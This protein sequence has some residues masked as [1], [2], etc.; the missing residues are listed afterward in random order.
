MNNSKAFYEYEFKRKFSCCLYKN[1]RLPLGE[2]EFSQNIERTERGD[3]YPLIYSQGEYT[4]E[5]GNGK[6]KLESENGE[7]CRLMGEFVPMAAYEII[8]GSLWGK[9]GFAFINDK[10]H[11]KIT[12]EKE[13]NGYY[14]CFTEN[15]CEERFELNDFNESEIV[16]SVQNR[17]EFF[18][19]YLKVNGFVKFITTFTASSFSDCL[20]ESVFSNTKACF[21]AKGN[22]IIKKASFFM[23]SGVS[24]ADIRAVKY[25]NGEVLNE[26]GKMYFT[27]SVRLESGGY[28]AVVSWVP[29]TEK[30][31]IV[32][33]LFFDV[34]DGQW[35]GDV[36]TSL[37]YDRK[38]SEWLLWVCSFSHGHI[39]GRAIMDSDPR[40]GRNVID[41]RL[42]D[43]QTENNDD[44][45]FLGKTGDED[46]DL[47]YDE[48]NGLWY[49]AIC[50]VSDI[51][52]KY[53]YHFFESV[54]P[55]DGFR[56]IGKGVCGS[57]TG[58]SFVRLNGEI[59]FVCGNGFEIT[60]EYRVYKFGEFDKFNLIKCDY[61]D[62]G[63]RGWGTV[64]GFNAATRQ[65][66]Y[67]MTFDRHLGSDFNWS[68]GN[69]YCFEAHI[70]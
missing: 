40:F 2:A 36:A 12:V 25:E 21:Y 15:G 5:S 26:N 57:E 13:N 1:L 52:G 68:Y 41:I 56:F 38:S 51:N 61:P 27:L 64:F 69:L 37:V 39:L 14:L 53:C 17:R 49:L 63:F 6:Y 65:R 11:I 3:K 54:N 67:F 44:A 58:G 18:D 29:G 28:Q 24:Q 50:R 20:Y 48:K 7:I 19:V 16:F 42:M 8:I 35:C 9:C 33:A 55:L 31:E 23:D 22:V 59:Y 70:S 10:T 4:E 60:S 30:F 32:G 34:G 43:K 62:G 45:A 46:P 47:I 66:I